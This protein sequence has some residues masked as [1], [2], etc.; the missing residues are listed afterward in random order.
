MNYFDTAAL[1]DALIQ[2]CHHIPSYWL[3]LTDWAG[4]MDWGHLVLSALLT[5]LAVNAVIVPA[6]LVWLSLDFTQPKRLLRQAHFKI[7]S[8]RKEVKHG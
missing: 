1:L 8:Q 6:A 4:N 2:L 5:I 7:P 3:Q